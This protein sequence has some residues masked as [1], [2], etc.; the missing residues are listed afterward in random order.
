MRGRQAE[1][2]NAALLWT[3]TRP[4]ADSLLKLQRMSQRA[5]PLTGALVVWSPV[6]FH[7]VS[8]TRGESRWE[9]EKKKKSRRSAAT[10]SRFCTSIRPPAGW[11]ISF[12]VSWMKQGDGWGLSVGQMRRCD[13]AASQLFPGLL[14]HASVLSFFFFFTIIIP[15]KAAVRG[16]RTGNMFRFAFFFSFLSLS[17]NLSRRERKRWDDKQRDFIICFALSQRLAEHDEAVNTEINISPRRSV[18]WLRHTFR[19]CSKCVNADRRQFNRFVLF[20]LHCVL[21][22]FQTLQMLFLLLFFMPAFVVRARLP[23]NCRR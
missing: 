15:M 9:L 23:Q 11:A 16:R 22:E 12:P 7:L 20:C 3:K 13:H 14:L 1:L 21:D 18:N 8:L 2:T 6:R 19:P 5:S 17:H 10:G 4:S